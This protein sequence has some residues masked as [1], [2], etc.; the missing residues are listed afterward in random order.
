MFLIYYVQYRIACR[1]ACI[2]WSF[3]EKMLC[4]KSRYNFFST[5]WKPGCLRNYVKEER[6]ISRN[7]GICFTT[8]EE[9]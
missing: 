7:T 8:Y 1:H 2:P 3:S 5:F 9:N 4:V 6:T